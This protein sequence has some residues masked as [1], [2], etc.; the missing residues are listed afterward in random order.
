MGK[1][2]PNNIIWSADVPSWSDILD[3]MK[4]KAL[5][6]GTII[7]LDRRSFAAVELANSKAAIDI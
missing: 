3:V 1:V 5:P 2:Q 6:P 7:K 4:A